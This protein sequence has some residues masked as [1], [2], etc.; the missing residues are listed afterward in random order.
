VLTTTQHHA[1]SGLHENTG[2][3]FWGEFPDGRREGSLGYHCHTNPGP[4]STLVYLTRPMPRDQNMRTPAETSET[5]NKGVQ[6]NSLSASMLK[7]ICVRA[8]QA[9]VLNEA[10]RMHGRIST[11]VHTISTFVHSYPISSNWC[12]Y[13]APF[14][15]AR[16]FRSRLITFQPWSLPCRSSEVSDPL[17]DIQSTVGVQNECRYI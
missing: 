9:H 11:L 6:T 14:P 5:M 2:H 17:V 13:F 12:F 10:T 16:F 1:L 3:P 7:Q 15:Q 8:N 4:R